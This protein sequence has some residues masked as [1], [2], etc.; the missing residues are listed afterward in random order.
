MKGCCS[1]RN[2]CGALIEISINEPETWKYSLVRANGRENL[3]H[4]IH[5]VLKARNNKTEFRLLYSTK[6]IGKYAEVLFYD[7]N[8]DFKTV[9]LGYTGTAVL[10]E[11]RIKQALQIL[12]CNML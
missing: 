6:K 11:E 7:M 4:Y 3:E 2:G 10:L 9:Q 8:L 12:L 5:L 1:T